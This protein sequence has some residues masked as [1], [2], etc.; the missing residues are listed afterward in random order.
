MKSTLI[1]ISSL[2]VLASIHGHAQTA[3]FS[4]DFES[5]SE[6]YAPPVNAITDREGWVMVRMGSG[7]SYDSQNFGV[8]TDPQAGSQVLKLEWKVLQGYYGVLILKDVATGYGLSGGE[9][10]D[11]TLRFKAKGFASG[12]Q[13]NPG[14]I[15]GLG[16]GIASNSDPANPS[17]T[18][19]SLYKDQ[20]ILGQWYQFELNL[21]DFVP[22][23]GPGTVSARDFDTTDPWFQIQF[24][25]RSDKL[26]S[27]SLWPT[28]GGTWGVLIDD[29][30]L[31][32][33]GTVPDYGPFNDYIETL[34]QGYVDSGDWIGW[35]Y[36]K[37]YPWVYMLDLNKY[38]YSAGG[39]WFYLPR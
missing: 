7:G 1:L 39:N 6:N 38:S 13:I 32:F 12:G 28:N 36:V 30:E 2:A 8:T 4:D 10:S 33:A 11:Y 18:R 35:V 5:Y 9:L 22:G 29:V 34:T 24:W 21:A 31:V 19:A 15:G 14:S 16:V 37:S 20:Q 27:E 17:A 26:S 25:L 23:S 3:V